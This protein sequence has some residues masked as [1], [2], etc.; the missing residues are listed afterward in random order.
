MKKFLS[1]AAGVAL[2][3]LPLAAFASSGDYLTGMV[4]PSGTTTAVTAAI[5]V[6]F[7]TPLLATIFQAQV[8]QILLAFAA[9]IVC[10]MVVRMIL[11]KVKHPHY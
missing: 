11:S 2:G 3:V 9:V 5:P 8:V 7:F 10:Y 4:V 6:Y 1:I